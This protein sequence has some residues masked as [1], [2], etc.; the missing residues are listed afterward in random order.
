MEDKTIMIDFLHDI[1]KFKHNGKIVPK[2]ILKFVP[3]EQLRETIESNQKCSEL[4]TEYVKSLEKNGPAE[5]NESPRIVPKENYSK[6]EIEKQHKTLSKIVDDIVVSF[7]GNDLSYIQNDKTE[8]MP[9]IFF[10]LN[11]KFGIISKDVLKSY[12]DELKNVGCKDGYERIEKF[13]KQQEEYLK[14][15]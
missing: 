11:L 1:I 9:L 3:E 4:F 14:S 10:F 8:I 2:K 5:V 6:E 7:K 13:I 12:A 15:I